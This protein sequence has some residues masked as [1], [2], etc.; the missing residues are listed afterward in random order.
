MK[1]SQI[2][3]GSIAGLV[4]YVAFFT[5][6]PPSF[7]RSVLSHPVGQV[8]AL[9]GILYVTSQKS[10]A[11]GLFL[12]IAY[13]TSSFNVLE[14]LDEKEQKPTEKEQPKSGAP[15]PDLKSIGKLADMMKG[16]NMPPN[17]G[18]KLTA[19]AGKSVTTPPPP[20]PTPPKPHSDPKVTEK[21]SLF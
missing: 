8:L 9:L 16:M 1:L 10:V 20:G 12:A 15:K 18:G 17:K 13:V 19:E 21:F 6:P 2:E 5:H 3:L 7:V 11:I 14:Y 4:L